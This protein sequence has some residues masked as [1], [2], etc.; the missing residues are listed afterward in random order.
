LSPIETTATKGGILFIT[1]I[2]FG[3]SYSCTAQSLSL[4]VTLFFPETGESVTED[5]FT[6]TS[7]TPGVTDVQ[8]LLQGTG[9]GGARIMSQP[10][11]IDCPGSCS[12]SYWQGVPVQLVA[13]LAPGSFMGWSGPCAPVVQMSHAKAGFL[14]G[15]GECNLTSGGIVR[16]TYG[17]GLSVAV[18]GVGKVVGATTSRRLSDGFL[19]PPA[20][21]C[22]GECLGYFGQQVALR[23]T[24]ASEYTFAGWTGPCARPTPNKCA[25]AMTAESQV[26]AIFAAV[27]RTL[28]DLT[29]S[30][31]RS[32]QGRRYQQTSIRPGTRLWRGETEVSHGRG[33]RES[34]GYF[35]LQQPA[36]SRQA[37]K[38]YNLAIWKNN[39][40][41]LQEYEVTEVWRAYV[42]RVA[43]GKG[44]QVL[45]P[46]KRQDDGTLK[47]LTIS[48]LLKKRW[49][50]RVG[51]CVPLPVS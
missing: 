24:A 5:E 18:T 44:T 25:L 49:I 7:P 4:S 8:V 11:G 9:A 13:S 28:R 22:P 48:Q 38:L 41:C 6:R 29:G 19:T 32:F 2:T 3:S 39:A 47:P 20:I 43:G 16:A 37:D 12:S 36:T 40:E 17:H 34:Q 10:A 31:Q 45:A 46:L 33:S 14:P 27:H 51:H 21:D 30:L 26:T 42:G 35:G 1:S 50:R 23:S 15:Q